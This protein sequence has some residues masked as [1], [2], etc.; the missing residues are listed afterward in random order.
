MSSF[1]LNSK[2]SLISFFIS[3]LTKLS[4]SRVLFSFHV[5]E[6][7][8]HTPHNNSGILL[9]MDWWWK[10]K[11]NRGTVKLTVEMVLTDM[12]RAFHPKAKEHTFFSVL[13]VKNWF[14]SVLRWLVHLLSWDQLLGKLFSNILLWGSVSLCSVP[15]GTFSKTDHINGHKTGLNRHKKNEIISCTLSDHHVLRLV[16]NNNN[17]SCLHLLLGVFSSFCSRAFSCTVKL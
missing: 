1:S 7:T 3:S 8:H 14:Y 9:A 10:Q 12:Y 6:S 16:L 15:H 11:V 2:K 4:L 5:Y 13:L 17:N